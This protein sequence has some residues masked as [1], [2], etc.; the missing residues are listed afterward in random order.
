M[1]EIR[2]IN[3]IC[4]ITVITLF[5]GGNV[6]SIPVRIDQALIS[7]KWP[8]TWRPYGGFVDEIEFVV[9][10]ETEIPLAM[11][12]LQNG[13]I[14]AYDERILT[15]YLSAL[16]RDQN[17]DVTFTPSV[18]Y[19]S[20]TLNC[21]KFPLNI[22]AFRR[23][24]AFGFDKY[25]AN[26]ECIGGVGMPQDSYIPLISTEWEVESALPEHFYEADFVSG[27]ASLAKAGFR[28]L[29]N[30]GWREYDAD[31]SGTWTS[32]DL[33]HNTYADGGIMQLFATAG[34]DPAIAACN[35]MIDGLTNMGIMAETV[36]MDFLAIFEEMWAGRAWVACWTEGV[37]YVNTVKLLYDNFAIGGQYNIDPYNYY[38]FTNGTIS[39]ILEDMVA[40]ND[41]NEVKQYAREASLLLA[42]EQ[43]QIVC[44]NDVNIGAHR[45][46][47]FD[48]WFE[49]AGAGVSSG[50]NWACATKVH[51]KESLG[52][53]YGGTFYYCLSD[54]MGTLNPY[55]QTTGYEATVF[56]YIYEPIVNVDPLTW[57]F[58]PGLA[59]EWD[60]EDTIAGEAPGV[61]DGQKYTYYLY[62]NETW[63]D[64]TPFTAQDVNISI[65]QW[66][67]SPRSG[68]EMQDIYKIEIPNDHTIVIYVSKAGFFEF[69]D[70]QVPYVV[71]AHI[72][73]LDLVHN[74]TSFNPTIAQTI[75]TGP[76]MAAARVPGEYIRLERHVNWRWDIRD[77]P[78]QTSYTT[79]CTHCF[80]TS[81]TAISWPP[82]CE[83][84]PPIVSITGIE[85]YGTYSGII[86][87]DFSVTDESLITKAEV[88][89][90]GGEIEETDTII[91]NLIS[92]KWVGSYNI[93]TTDFPNDIYRVTIRIY[94]ACDN[95]QTIRYDVT[96]SNDFTE[97]STGTVEIPSL[98]PGFDNI[99][100]FLSL[101]VITIVILRRQRK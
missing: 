52:G 23:A 30:D 32:G 75:G 8:T 69:A 22:T 27:N 11:L 51:L 80:T 40:T 65:I 77:V 29:D 89:I 64:G 13:D 35:I 74:I 82:G 14:D 12:A 94:D 62:E 83:Q 19:R 34:Y 6:F 59:Y 54:N 4:F 96:F 78:S 71:P 37:P 2:L 1:R 66:K 91:L 61:L 90:K 98:S 41:I 68:P 86:T 18:R 101:G 79:E 100:V 87:I 43:P 55:F 57:D 92:G 84:D 97:E 26:V 47:R 48:G 81:T 31:G 16:V 20:L 85:Y 72:Y 25:R 60:I 70:T 15:D 63:H 10:T 73:G 93:D 33:D 95:I 36:E 58:E 42:F 24:M 53:P 76:Y 28:D 50:D 39:A 5:C 3:I 7:T 99:S 9:F 56:Q 46:D 88:T 49:F 45:N 21:E 44:Y 38:H 67:E 17:I